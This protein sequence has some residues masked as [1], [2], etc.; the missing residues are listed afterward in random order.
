MNGILIEKE[1]A[2]RTAMERKLVFPY[3]RTLLYSRSI[4]F[5]VLLAFLVIVFSLVPP[6][7]PAY[8][9]GLAALLVASFL[10]FGVSP[11]LTQHW[12]TRSRVILRQGWYLRVVVPFADLESLRVAEDSLGYRMPLGIHRPLGR[13][14]LFVTGGRT[15]LLVARLRRARRF[16]Q[17]L[18]LPAMEIV[19]DVEHPHEFLRA[20]EERRRLFTPVETDRSDA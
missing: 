16:W 9:M 8:L 10:V 4:T 2:P 11:A 20:F 3:G 14:S 18:G 6:L 13:P 12:M 15:G 19:F 5:G 7:P 1:R 17:V